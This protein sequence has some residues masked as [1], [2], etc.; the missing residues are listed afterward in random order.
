MELDRPRR[1]NK[2]KEPFI[3]LERVNLYADVAWHGACLRP[4]EMYGDI[5]DS[6]VAKAYNPM[7]ALIRY[8]SAIQAFIG[9]QSRQAPVRILFWK[10]ASYRRRINAFAVI[11]PQYQHFDRIAGSLSGQRVGRSGPSDFNAVDKNAIAANGEE[12]AIGF[13]MCYRR[14]VG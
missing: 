9:R 11:Q 3:D 2:I 6:T 1:R 10:Q 12:Y 5:A 13:C 14:Y 4:Q 8:E 7:V